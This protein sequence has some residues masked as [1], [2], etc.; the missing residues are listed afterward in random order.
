[1]LHR[2][3]FLEIPVKGAVWL[4]AGAAG[5]GL[6]RPVFAAT[7]PDIAVVKGDPAAATRAAVGMLGGMASVVKTGARVVIKPNMSFTSPAEAGSNTHPLVVQSLAV[8]CW[9]AGA[10]SVLI[11]DHTL[12]P[13]QR[14]LEQSGIAAAGAQVRDG[15]VF[16]VNDADHY[17]AV[18]INGGRE[19]SGTEVVT[20]V[21]KADVLIA[22]PTAKSHSSAGVSLSLKGMMGLVYDRGSMHRKGL[23]ACIVDICTVLKAD[24]TVIDATHVLMT[25]GPRGPGGVLNGRKVIA[26]RDMVAADALT[27]AEFPW[28]GRR[29]QARQVGH[30]RQAHERGLGRMDFENLRVSRLEL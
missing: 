1:M 18:K 2:R 30:I 10:S 25:G 12:A 22:A 5:L 6:L 3:S 13:P 9:E 20:E 11:L 27:V 26:S 17:K 8:M 4:G 19:M 16:A 29:Y 15:M 14:C 24:L 7:E 21:L 23:D 28:Y